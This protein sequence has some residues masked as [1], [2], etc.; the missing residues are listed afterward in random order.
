MTP[1]GRPAVLPEAMT[2]RDALIAWPADRALAL[3]NALIS[4]ELQAC[5]TALV[6]QR[7]E[8]RP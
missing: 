4:G 3:T 6:A 7:S 2:V 1:L 5:V 8:V